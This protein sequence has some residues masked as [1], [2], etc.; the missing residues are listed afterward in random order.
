LKNQKYKTDFLIVGAGPVGCVLAERLSNKLKLNCLII[1]K[2]KHIAGNCFDLKNKN[3]LLY[4]KY[5]PHYLRFKNTKIKDYLS[6]FT[7]WIK[8]DYIVKSYVNKKFYNFPINLNTIESFFD[9]KFKNLKSAKKFIKKKKICIKNPKNSE[10]FILSK[11][12]PELYNN[13]YKNYSIKQ[14]GLHP[15]FLNKN[16]L[17]RVPIRLNRDNSYVN[18]KIKLMP[19]L[20]FTNM[21]KNMIAN[22]KITIKLNT[23]FNKIKKNVSYKFLIYTGP[24]DEYFNFKYGKLNWRSLK[25]NFKTYKKKYLQDCVQYNFPNKFKFT[26]KIEIKHVTKQKSNYTIIS[27]EYPSKIGDPYYPINTKKNL[28]LYLKYLKLTKKEKNT[29]FEGRLASY[30]YLNTDEVIEKALILFEKIKKKFK[31]KCIYQ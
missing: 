14:W 24:I 25:F 2:R 16:V 11:I 18:E 31:K 5:G 26:R 13:F 27:K 22:K 28:S 20:G 15:K 23:S 10:E 30:K 6:N 9:L 29:Y 4:H 3:K 8:G 12:G 7:S 19:R 1:D 21:F 17:G